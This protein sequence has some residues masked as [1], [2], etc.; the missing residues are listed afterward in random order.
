MEN[1]VVELGIAGIGLVVFAIVIRVMWYKLESKDA[2][3]KRLNM[4]VSDIALKT[5]ERM[6]KLQTSIDTHA[7][8]VN[9]ILGSG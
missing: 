3:I 8:I 2:E 1:Y 7:T 9:K 4:L 6:G 5:Q